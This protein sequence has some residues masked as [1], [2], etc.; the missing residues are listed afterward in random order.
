[1]N[2]E[3]KSA[4]EAN[5][6]EIFFDK[7]TNKLSYK[8]LNGIVTS[9]DTVN[10]LITIQNDLIALEATVDALP[11][12]PTTT[13]VNISSAQILAMDTTPI[14]LLPA[15]GVNKYYDIEK[16]I[17]EYTYGTSI[18]D[19][20]SNTWVRC[21]FSSL[22]ATAS[23]P[24]YIVEAQTLFEQASSRVVIAERTG[25]QNTISTYP[26]QTENANSIVDLNTEFLISSSASIGA[27]TPGDGTLRAIITYTTRTFGA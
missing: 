5:I 20:S 8:N 23:T 7:N 10:D 18:Y 15:P 4:L 21:Y 12:A 16:V 26:R 2:Y 11:A 24:L 25:L 22:G 27:F 1:M 17:L 19:V 3:I 6:K 13:V 9:I 14:E